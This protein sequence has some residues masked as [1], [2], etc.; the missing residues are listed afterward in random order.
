MTISLKLKNP[1]VFKVATAGGPV[2][3]WKWYEIMYGERYMGTPQNNPE[4][5]KNAS[6]LNYVD[7]LQ[8]KLLIMQGYQDNTVVPQ[9]CIEFLKQCVRHDKQLDFFLY[10]EHPHNVG[11]KDRIHLYKKIYTYYKENL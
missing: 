1:G 4:G 2:I 6:L 11:G 8:G 10:T 3:D 9:H 7:N 5:F